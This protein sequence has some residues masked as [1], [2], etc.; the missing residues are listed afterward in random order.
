MG[1]AN[2]NFG[3]TVMGGVANAVGGAAGTAINGAVGG[4][5]G[6]IFAGYND[7]RQINQQQKLTNMQLAANKDM[8][9]YNFQQQYDMWQKTNYPAQVEQLEKAGLN[10][11]L[12]YAKGGPGGTTG[13]PSGGIGGGTAPSGGHEMMD[14]MGMGMQSQQM[15][16][17]LKMQQAQIELTQAQAEATKIHAQKEAGVDTEVAKSQIDLNNANTGNAT[18]DAALK[19]AQTLIQ[20]FDLNYKQATQADQMGI[21]HETMRKLEGESIT[22][23]IHAN[24]DEAM[25]NTY[26]KQIQA[27][28]LSTVL[29]QDLTR[30]QTALTGQ[31]SR[32]AQT[33]VM[34]NDQ[35]IQ[36]MK[37]DIM[38][39]WN[40]LQND[41]QKTEFLRQ[42][43]GLQDAPESIIKEIMSHVDVL[44]GRGLQKN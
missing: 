28:L 27:N 22:T 20:Q 4:L 30:A 14:V 10:P 40:E 3:N 44:V 21:I 25:Q 33:E 15:M 36:T 1:D 19:H 42:H 41:N 31:Q 32:V 2:D 39:G 5:L 43:L 16:M 35:R 7:K 24:I 38:R 6:E 37:N 29:Q 11:A 9:A 12:L 17:Q 8:S 26:R 13:A 34:V 23:L 18:A